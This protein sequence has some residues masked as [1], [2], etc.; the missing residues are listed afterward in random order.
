MMRS[1][2]S[3][4]IVAAIALGTSVG[5]VAAFDAG[6]AYADPIVTVDAGAAIVPLDAGSGSSGSV[7]AGS[8]AVGSGSSDPVKVVVSVS[9]PMPDPTADPLATISLWTKLYKSGAFFALGILVVFTGLYFADKQIAWLQQGKRGV[10]VAAGLGCLA[11]LVVPATQGST[12][13]LAMIFSALTT[14]IALV[15]NPKASTTGTT[16]TSSST[17]AS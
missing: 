1:L 6:Q 14:G 15:V 4:V 8:A 3:L 13:T 9:P 16:S 7:V 12:P 10:Y 5:L 17:P 11:V 2:K